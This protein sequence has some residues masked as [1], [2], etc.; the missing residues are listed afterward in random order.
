MISYSQALPIIWRVIIGACLLL[1]M[2]GCLQGESDDTKFAGI[3]GSGKIP[4][5]D[6]PGGEIGLGKRS[7]LIVQGSINGFGSVIVHGEHYDTTDTDFYR[8]GELVSEANFEVGDRIAVNGYSDESGKLFAEQ[9]FFEPSVTGR[10][11]AYDDVAGIA[12]VLGQRVRIDSQTVL[13]AELSDKML[14]GKEVTISG[15]L[16]DGEILATRVTL[17]ETPQMSLVRGYIYDND[18]LQMQASVGNLRVNYA[19]IND[20]SIVEEDAGVVFEGQLSQTSP[21][22]LIAT[23][24]FNFVTNLE[25]SDV[26]VESAVIAG[27]V[28][29][30]EAKHFWVN[31]IK[32]VHD[33]DT[34]V[35][36]A[37]AKVLSIEA[38]KGGDR[39]VVKGK[40][41]DAAQLLAEDIS[42]KS[43]VV[44][45][46]ITGAVT[47]LYTDETGQQFVDIDSQRVALKSE[48]AI[49]DLLQQHSRLTF[50]TLNIG[51][52]LVMVVVPGEPAVAVSI[53]RTQQ[54][55]NDR[56]FDGTDELPY[57]WGFDFRERSTSDDDE[58]LLFAGKLLS[59]DT[60]LN[61]LVL[62]N[63]VIRIK[64]DSG[65]STEV[66]DSEGNAIA[67]NTAAAEIGELLKAKTHRTIWVNL[68]GD[69]RNDVVFADHI[70]IKL[71]WYGRE[72]TGQLIPEE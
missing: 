33:A 24:A 45:Q 4:L 25:Q 70:V 8:H 66:F 13:G 20:P 28:R 52:Y 31:G 49:V 3:D 72:I 12:T 22:I 51:D 36:S 46:T 2:T 10:I 21:Q 60:S 64:S 30:I 63:G 48:T 50:D 71:D 44:T 40:P 15:W 43:N 27:T 17:G 54:G 37:S 26:V 65:N 39:L 34:T 61:T 14:F 9:V 59:V 23:K 58:N 69:R 57:D 38:I 41:I 67:A 5:P 7:P 6:E 11:E 42:I 62:S 35:T 19:N 53:K 55:V 18:A 47:M 68:Q 1:L 16:Q 29:N 32:I 56:K